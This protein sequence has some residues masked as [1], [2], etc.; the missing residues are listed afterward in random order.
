MIKKITISI[1][2]IMSTLILF[3]QNEPFWTKSA[4]RETNYP[5]SEYFIGYQMGNKRS[6]ETI[7]AAKDRIAKES[8]ALL[9]ESIKVNIQSAK[10]TKT[11]SV[12]KGDYEQINSQFESAIQTF[13]NI[14][15]IGIKTETY[16]SEKEGIIHGF[17]FVK[18]A[19]L[20]TYH[21][22]NLT[23]HINQT[24]SFIK[25]A[26]N[27]EKNGEKSKARQEIEKAKKTFENVLYAQTM[28]VVLNN[29]D[30]Q[31]EKTGELYNTITQMYAQLAQAVYVFV[32]SN[33]D[34]FGKKV[35]I[36]A[37][38][39][40]ADLAVNGCSFVENAEQAD[41]KLTI[42]ASTR[43]SDASNGFVFCYADVAIELF[44]NHKQ[45]A[46]FND[47]LSEKGGSNSTEKAARKAMENAVSKIISKI[48]NW[49]K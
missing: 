5:T 46:V 2:L 43:E 11:N 34:L 32:E 10:T 18:K 21:R 12:S 31:Q 36:I 14:E 6:N 17:S 44:D 19:E 45:K 40:K 47:E 37:N 3:S 24:E 4:W 23:S 20:I 30:L 41:F 13:S 39:L 35:N 28:L 42:N 29:N 26:Q 15:L 48:S 9:S 27:L 22:N 8:Q 16:Y 25:T 38:K 1:L 49:I 33:E 7:D